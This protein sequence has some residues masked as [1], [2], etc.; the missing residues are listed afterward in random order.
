M[1]SPMPVPIACGILGALAGLIGGGF[2]NCFPVWVGASAGCSLG[3]VCCIVSALMPERAE[4][5]PVA[6]VVESPVIIQNIYIIN[7]TIGANKTPLGKN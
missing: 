4:Q 3:C 1:Y 7:D 2:N 5:L 6:R